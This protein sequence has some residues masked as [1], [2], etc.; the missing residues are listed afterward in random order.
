[1]LQASSGG[2]PLEVGANGASGGR[3][4]AAAEEEPPVL[5]PRLPDHALAAH[6]PAEA[7]H[8]GL[9]GLLAGMERRGLRQQLLQPLRLRRGRRRHWAAV[10]RPLRLLLARRRALA[11]VPRE[12]VRDGES[13]APAHEQ[14]EKTCRVARVVQAAV[15]AALPHEPRQL[16]R[17]LEVA[18]DPAEDLLEGD[19]QVDP[20]EEGTG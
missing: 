17:L 19:L 4:V 5:G 15:R 11:G 12:R 7:A 1:M 14:R 10:G 6:H 18:A 9:P 3:P 13:E 8:R 20:P 16:H 2:R